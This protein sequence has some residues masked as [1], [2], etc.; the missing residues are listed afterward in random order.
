MWNVVLGPPGTGKTTYLLNKVE[1]FLEAGI[2]P[3]KLGYVAFTKKAANEALVRAV[4]KFDFDPKEL[5]YFRTLHSLCYHWLGLTR[6]DVMARSNLREFSRTIGERINSAW[7]GE[8]MMSLKSKGDTMRFIENM[9]RNRC[10]GFREQWN[11][12]GS[13]ISWMHFD[14]FVNNYTNYKEGNF[15]IDYT[16]MLEMFLHSNGKPKLD[17]LIVDEAQALSELQWSV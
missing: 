7:D 17:V 2:K 1:M 4:D 8:N 10:V 15:L 5:V 16:Y 3:D 6:S 14:W 11:Q 12:A 13:N 9:A